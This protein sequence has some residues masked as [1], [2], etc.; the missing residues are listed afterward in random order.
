M[1]RVPRPSC[2]FV[3]E[4]GD[5][6]FDRRPTLSRALEKLHSQLLLTNRL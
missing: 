3:R 6:D 4:G 5:F 1:D 2:V